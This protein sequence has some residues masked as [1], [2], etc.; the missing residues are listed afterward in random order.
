[1]FPVLLSIAISLDYYS[2]GLCSPVI[3]IRCFINLFR[4]SVAELAGGQ[5]VRL[6]DSN[7]LQGT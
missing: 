3:I 1:M 5:Q 6:I 4:V 2:V 7:K